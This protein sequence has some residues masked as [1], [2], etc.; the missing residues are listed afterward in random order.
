MYQCLVVLLFLLDNIVIVIVCYNI[1][2][3]CSDLQLL[4]LVFTR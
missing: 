2:L 4:S 3:L 1:V